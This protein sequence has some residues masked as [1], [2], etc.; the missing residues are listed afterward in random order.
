M[1]ANRIALVVGLG[2]LVFVVM[3][4]QFLHLKERGRIQGLREFWES[5]TDIKWIAG[6]M[7]DLALIGIPVGAFFGYSEKNWDLYLYAFYWFLF[8]G[9]FEY[10]LLQRA[11]LLK[12][13]QKAAS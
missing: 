8:F 10:K 5:E 13:M 4:G 1:F 6:F 12:K 3:L 7:H 11:D 2:I 9:L